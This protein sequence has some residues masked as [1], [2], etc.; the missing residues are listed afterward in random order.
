MSEK[1]ERK[2]QNP[3]TLEQC[4]YYEQSVASV[5]DILEEKYKL[6]KFIKEVMDNQIWPIFIQEIET[7]SFK[8]LTLF[9]SSCLQRSLS[10][11]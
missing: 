11:F 7:F 2:L 9:M 4:Q 1:N 3:Q 8:K 5:F 6:P 10:S